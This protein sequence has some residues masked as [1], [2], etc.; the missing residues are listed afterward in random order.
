M[1]GKVWLVGAGPGDPELLTLKA[2]RVL[3]AA[4]VVMIDDLVN[5]ALLVHC[6]GARV[7]RV[8]KRGGCR[9]TPQAFI[10]RL[11]LRYARQG[12]CV[13]RLKGGDPCIFGRGGE[14]AAWLAER[15][16]DCELVNGITA[17]LAG[18]TA[19]GIP[20]TLRGVSRGVTL[21][22][23]HT[24]DDSEPEWAALAASG[25]TLVVYMGVARLAALQAGLLAG[26]MA[27]GMPLAMIENASLPEQRERRSTLATLLQDASA[28]RLSSPAILVIGEVAAEAAVSA[29]P[30]SA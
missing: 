30:L 6:P 3:G 27:P 22:T 28:F 21:V 4:D 1:N 12:R 26:G 2:A 5:P 20:L 10:H 9:S 24:Q 19:C 16:V 13:V 7:V 29:L 11:M 14:E 15:G 25:T 18:A 17:G 8:G 23:A